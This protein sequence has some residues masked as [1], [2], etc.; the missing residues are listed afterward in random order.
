MWIQAEERLKHILAID[1]YNISATKGLEKIESEKAKYDDTA[2]LETRDERLRQVEE[3]WY[4]PIVN[5]DA[6]AISRSKSG[7]AQ[8][9]PQ[10]LDVG[11][12][13]KTLLVSLDFNNSSIEDATNYLHIQSKRLDPQGKGI[14]FIIQPEASSTAKP[15]TLTLNN[16]PLEEALRYI[17]QLANVKS[18]VQDYAIS[19]VPFNQSTD[20][21]ISRTFIVQRLTL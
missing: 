11:Q 5:K 8:P 19:I 12:K 2:R 14:N 21:L 13:L 16:V 15:I 3:T 17:C 20:D 7:D 1:P 10:T 18:K 6:D 4:P 9:G